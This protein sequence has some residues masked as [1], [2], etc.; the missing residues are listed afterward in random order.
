MRESR[1]AARSLWDGF[2]SF[3][4][5]QEAE[6]LLRFFPRQLLHNEA[7]V[8]QDVVARSDGDRAGIGEDPPTS[9]IE[10]RLRAADGDDPRGDP[11]A[12]G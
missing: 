5:I 8:R 6:G 11:K 3:D 4:L 1:A 7:G 10:N 9:E 2:A 12:H